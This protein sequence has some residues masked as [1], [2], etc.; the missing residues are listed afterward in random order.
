MTWITSAG[1]SPA[2]VDRSSSRRNARTRYRSSRSL[3]SLTDS[4]RHEISRSSRDPSSPLRHEPVRGRKMDGSGRAAHRLGCARRLAIRDELAENDPRV[5]ARA[6]APGEA[7]C[8]RRA[9]V[10][11]AH[12]SPAAGSYYSGCR[13]AAKREGVCDLGVRVIVA[14]EATTVR[15]AV[16]AGVSAIAHRG[17]RG[18]RELSGRT[19]SPELRVRAVHAD[20]RDP[21][22]GHRLPDVSTSHETRRGAARRRLE[23]D[24]GARTMLHHST[25]Q[26][27][28]TRRSFTARVSSIKAATSTSWRDVRSVSAGSVR[29][30]WSS[31]A[32]VV[33]VAEREPSANPAAHDLAWHDLARELR[34]LAAA[35]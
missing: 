34:P 1:E 27:G 5:A 28:H 6:A 21:R 24:A 29:S 15:A 4:V 35:R 25:T 16:R 13:R 32:P 30:V 17:Q 18:R 14:E 23:R 26:R 10:A 20:E 8:D 22:S 31:R 9:E 7:R 11:L 3:A 19:G 33:I 12:R 2:S